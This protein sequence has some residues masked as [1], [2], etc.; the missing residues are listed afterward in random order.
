MAKSAT[1]E[2]ASKPQVRR[3][4][5]ADWR[6][7][8]L[9]TLSAFLCVLAFLAAR[10]QSGHD[11]ALGAAATP[12]SEQLVRRRLVI[13]RKVVHVT[14][15]PADPVTTPRMSSSSP[16]PAPISTAPPAPVPAPAPAPVTRV[17]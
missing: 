14:V 10:M 5:P 7:V 11:P 6:S 9:G 12:A 15:E 4:T 16:A 1:T 2:G 13:K 3:R 8:A 17:S